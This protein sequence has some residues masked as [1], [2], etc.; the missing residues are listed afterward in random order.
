VRK[1]E[2]RNRSCKRE[3]R[4]AGRLGVTGQANAA[5]DD[6]EPKTCLWKS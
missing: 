1:R 5:E 4:K 6:N 3:R 2:N